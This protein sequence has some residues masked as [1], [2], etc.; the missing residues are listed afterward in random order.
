[1]EKVRINVRINKEVWQK[2]KENG[3]NI[4]AFLELRLQ[5]HLNFFGTAFS[6][7][8]VECGRRDSNPGRGLGRP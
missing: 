5:E 7:K 6:K 2:A 8:D 4:S 3:I 1:M